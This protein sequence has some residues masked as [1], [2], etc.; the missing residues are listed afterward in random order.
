MATDESDE[1]RP[2]MTALSRGIDILQC[3]TPAEREL[4]SRE[5]MV[6]T[7]LPRPTVF[8]ITNTLCQLGLLHYSEARQVFRPT[9]RLLTLAAPVLSHLAVRQAAR[10]LLREL[11]DFSTGQ[12]LLCVGEGA[13]LVIAETAL[14]PNADSIRLELGTQFSLTHTASG[15]A[16]LSVL[17][18]EQRDNYLKIYGKEDEKHSRIFAN[19]FKDLEVKGYCVASRVTRSDIV[20]IAAPLRINLDNQYFSLSTAV[21]PFNVDE[22]RIDEIGVRLAAFARNLEVSLGNLG[23]LAHLP[24]NRRGPAR[25][26]KPRAA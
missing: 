14:A 12:A 9:I 24:L 3:F 26:R 22:A 18:R 10:P 16:Y 25:A 1:S 19:A 21:L 8:R 23:D 13:D 20:G 15:L 11:A 7:G 6:R 4:D 5:L 2:M 17:P